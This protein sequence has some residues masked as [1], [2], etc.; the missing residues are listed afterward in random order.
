MQIDLLIA[1]NGEAGLVADQAFPVPPTAVMFDAQERVLTLEFTAAMD[2][3]VLNIPVSDDC[4]AHLKA[5][6]FMHICAIERGKMVLAGQL[7]L[8]V[9][10]LF[11]E[12]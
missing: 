4:V 11:E 12:G 2:S 1:G 6:R 5:A 7:P 8:M 10:D 3:K 9:Q